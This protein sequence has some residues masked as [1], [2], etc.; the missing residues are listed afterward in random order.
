MPLVKNG[1]IVLSDLVKPGDAQEPWLGSLPAF[2]E[3]LHPIGVHGDA[4]MYAVAALQAVLEE[5]RRTN[6][7]LERLVA[8]AERKP[9]RPPSFVKRS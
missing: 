2:L 5:Q 3:Q 4:G 1:P 9:G 7:L 8:V 6:A